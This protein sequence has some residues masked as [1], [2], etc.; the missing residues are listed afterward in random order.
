MSGSDS[1][2]GE[3]SLLVWLLA[4]VVAV[5]AGHVFIGWLRVARQQPTLRASGLALLLAALSLGTGIASVLVLAVSAEGLSFTP[6]W[7][8]PVVPALWLGGCAAVLPLAWWLMHSRE[9]LA[10]GVCGLLLGALAL[11]LQAGWLLATGFRP[12]LQWPPLFVAGAALLHVAGMVAALR[13]GLGDRAGSRRG[14][15]WR[16][17]AALLMGMSL[18]GAQELLLLG[19]DLHTQRGSVFSDG[20]PVSALSLAGGVLVPLVLAVMAFDLEL[21][22][23]LERRSGPD[24]APPKRRRRRHRVRML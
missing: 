11:G 22:R 10:L 7:S 4:T 16:V 17:G 2:V 5:L 8:L 21:R 15:L 13:V 12:G 1:S 6:G 9:P 20:V 14:A 19:A 23:N 3:Y 18:V 24:M